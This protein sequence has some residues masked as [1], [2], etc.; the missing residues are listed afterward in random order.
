[1]I[2]L[3]THIWRWLVCKQISK[4]SNQQLECIRKN[5]NDGLGVSIISCWE[6]AKK[7][8][9]GKLELNLSGENTGLGSDITIDQWITMALQRRG[10]FLV[11]L[12][13][14]IVIESTRLPGTFHRDPMDQLIVATAR[15]HNCKLV[16]SDRKI[17]DYPHV[18]TI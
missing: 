5:E 4:L 2:L 18:E 11:D 8:E 15:I 16:T 9:I 13:T 14:R 12:T 7:F 1:M 17:I 3:D 6:I 10:I